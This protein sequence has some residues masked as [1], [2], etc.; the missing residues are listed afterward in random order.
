MAALIRTDENIR[1]DVLEELK[2]DPRVQSNEIGVAV[3]DGI[4]TLTGWVDS[5]L[6][7]IAAEEAAHRVS[8]VKAVAN[9]IE[10]RLPG[11]AERTDGRPCRCCGQRAQ[12][13]CCYSG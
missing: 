13:G 7:K 10:V 12:V 6:K 2:W 11:F 1:A 3:K 9:N 8:S 4:V 5:Y